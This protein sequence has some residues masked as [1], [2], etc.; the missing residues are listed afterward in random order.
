MAN[1]LKAGS[2]SGGPGDLRPG[3]TLIIEAKDKTTGQ[4]LKT[5]RV[6]RTERDYVH[7]LC[8]AYN[9]ARTP[10]AIDRGLEWIVTAAGELKLSDDPEWSRKHRRQIAARTET[11][12]SR[13]NRNQL[14][15]ER[16]LNAY[17]PE[18]EDA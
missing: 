1:P 4:V 10:E 12:R 17:Q 3:D 16:R 13:H 9:D 7:D 15:A 5:I 2:G 14:E 11:E 18:G 6:H 8:D